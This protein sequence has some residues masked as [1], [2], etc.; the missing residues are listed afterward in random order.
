MIRKSKQS[1]E[2][3]AKFMGQRYCFQDGTPNR[4]IIATAQ[5]T[6]GEFPVTVTIKGECQ[7]DD[8]RPGVLYRFDGEWKNHPKYG[9]QF[10]FH[11]FCQPAPVTRDAIEGYLATCPNIGEMRARQICDALGLDCLAKIKDDPAVLLKIRGLT[12]PMVEEI[13][14]SLVDRESKEN[15]VIELKSLLSGHGLP[16]RLYGKLEQDFGTAAPEM[17]RNNPYI[18]LRYKGVG[19]ETADKVYMGLGLSP[20]AMLRQKHCLAWIV[21]SDSS[22]S[23]WI[24]RKKALSQLVDKIG[25][26]ADPLEA[27]QAALADELLVEESDGGG[28]Y[29]AVPYYAACEKYV[30]DW[31]WKH[32]AKPGRWPETLLC[33]EGIEPSAHQREHYHAAIRAAVAAITGSPG[34]GKTWLVGRI[35]KTLQEKGVLFAVCAPTGKAALRVVESLKNQGVA[36]S[37]STIHGLLGS[38]IDDGKWV[39]RYNEM[40]KLPH[41]VIIIDESSMIDISLLCSLLKAVRDDCDILFVGDPDQLS[42]V[43][44]GAPL[45]DMIAAG[46]PCGRL[47]EI[48][49]NSGEIVEACAAIRDGERITKIARTLDG[50]ENLCILNVPQDLDAVM[51]KI[52]EIIEYEGREGTL[53]FAAVKNV[54]IIVAINEKSALSRKALNER[55][56]DYF[57]AIP[58]D[59]P[60]SDIVSKVRKFR[61]LDKIICL[62]N[63]IAP[64]AETGE[65]L[66]VANGDIGFLEMIV[67]EGIVVDVNE[68]HVIVPTFSDLWG[69]AN[70][71]LG[72]AI[73][74]HKSQG[75][76]WPVVII[77]LD[78][79]FAA[80]MICDRHWIYTAISRAKT[81]C[82]L[83]GSE[84]SITAMS[85]ISKM[86]ERKTL[87]V[88]RFCE[89]RWSHLNEEFQKEL[90]GART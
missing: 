90:E 1:V 20:T 77:V 51:K 22:G 16:K 24:D 19:F 68:N 66:R 29:L 81:R 41:D 26:V 39:F 12:A 5:M 31:L 82:Y 61:P 67:K 72:Y 23:V 44:R 74:C 28:P 45:R 13:R 64:S 62:A 7:P 59:C 15:M 32:A 48:R 18:L 49:R 30:A 8:L 84:S 14:Q 57:N 83:L 55:L 86:W 3:N 37:A 42:P 63:G 65:E 4:C 75:S 71:D 78:S 6:D 58:A 80:G 52:K 40:E 2:I 79:S 54:Q 47:T 53:D 25:D 46:I 69:E 9:K 87:L 85:R 27:V 76:E 88:E 10:C 73:S 21:S 36:V 11:S 35:I 60:E 34:T 38:Q 89:M 33:D 50:P 43:G 17:I 70:W 56:Q